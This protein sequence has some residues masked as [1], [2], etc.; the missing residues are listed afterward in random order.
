MRKNVEKLFD[1]NIS[2][3]RISKDINITHSTITRLRNG[4]SNIDDAKFI[5]IKKLSD[6]YLNKKKNEEI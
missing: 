4:N 5:H 3:Y 6:Y 1:S 2:S